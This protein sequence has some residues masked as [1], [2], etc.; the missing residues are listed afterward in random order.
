MNPNILNSL[1]SLLEQL[2]ELETTNKSFWAYLTGKRWKKLAAAVRSAIVLFQ[3]GE[4]VPI[5]FSTS[6][7]APSPQSLPFEKMI[8]IGETLLNFLGNYRLKKV[9]ALAIELRR[10][11]VALRYRLEASNGGW[12]SL[13]SKEI[14]PSAFERIEQYATE[15]KQKQSILFEK[16]ITPEEKVRIEEALCYP[17][18]T[19]LLADSAE[20]QASFFTWILRDKNRPA[21]FI[22]FPQLIQKMIE[23]NMQG[24]ISRSGK[25]L[26]KIEKEFVNPSLTRKIVSL[27][28]EGKRA[29]ILDENASVTLQGNWTLT[30][31]E[32]FEV[33]RNKGISVGNLEFFAQGIYN[34]NSHQWGYW[35]QDTKTIVEMDVTKKGWW[36][37]LPILELISVDEAK[38][39]LG[40][41]MNGILWN[42]A[43]TSTRGT[44]TLN[45]DGC[46]S[47]LQ[48]AV[49]NGDGNYALYDFG[50]FAKQ[51]PTSLFE[52]LKLFCYNLYATVAYPD[53]N[54][55]YTHRQSAYHSFPLTPKE[56]A[57]LLERIRRDI[58]LGRAD[59]FV[60]QIESEN[61][62][63]W[64][65]EHLE[66]VLGKDAIPNLYRTSLLK[67][68]PTGFMSFIFAFIRILPFFCQVPALMAL[69]LP[70]GAKEPTWIIEQGDSVPKALHLASFWTTGE[71][72]LPAYL[73]K[74]QELGH[75]LRLEG[76][77]SYASVAVRLIN[78]SC[79]LALLALY[80]HLEK[81]AEKKA[82]FKEKFSRKISSLMKM[83]LSLKPQEKRI[84]DYHFLILGYLGKINC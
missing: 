70:F 27:P 67:T 22:L 60:Y 14:E 16:N 39:R 4:A 23:C 12:D 31:G 5:Q 48:L 41:H 29:S 13:S 62:A 82:L 81:L 24:R 80:L 65:N 64:L 73:H 2:K 77:V 20:L 83:I 1:S 68:E 51:F 50:K 54:V 42:A 53:E 43:A 40:P 28:F 72:F 59:N 55:F 18:F 74:K 46:H 38:R 61:C 63:K 37:E 47:Y 56:G 33:F 10:Y 79:Q 49:P 7:S 8:D 71:V 36:K 26:L 32:V 21:P 19:L 25:D 58:V 52:N 30:I 57:N 9:Q 76:L 44:T 3:Q 34:W 45:Y 35:D 78:P 84:F 75:L 6:S 11:L 66:A 69:H 17:A 15:W